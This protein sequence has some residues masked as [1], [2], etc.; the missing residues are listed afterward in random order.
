MVFDGLVAQPDGTE[1]Y[2]C[3]ETG[4][5]NAEAGE[6]LGKAAGEKLKEQ[7]GEKFF[8]GLKVDN[9]WG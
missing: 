7:A 4:E 9:N 1:C 5:W 3:N 2:T 8:E 6:A